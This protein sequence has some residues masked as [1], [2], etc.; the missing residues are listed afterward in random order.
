MEH[1]KKMPILRECVENRHICRWFYK[2]DK[3]C[4]Y[5]YINDFNDKFL[6]GQEEND[7]E[8]NGYMIG[9]V[10]GLRKAEVKNDIYEE[11]NRMNGAAEQVKNPDIDI[12]SWQSIF[13]SLKEQDEWVA[14]ENE[15]NKIFH[16]GIIIKAGKNKLT[17]REF[18]AD[19]NRL[20]KTKI[21]YKEITSVSFKTRYI[22]NWRKYL[23]RTKEG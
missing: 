20:E 10:D 6:L 17:M 15:N 1:S 23:K 3:S 21:P 14:V 19:G 5:C 12:S 22:D 18:D 11:I 8:L 13:K 7:F 4:R 16:I 9:K 2:Y